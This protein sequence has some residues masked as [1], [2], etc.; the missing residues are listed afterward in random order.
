M[1]ERISELE[2]L[3]WE[4]IPCAPYWDGMPGKHEL[5]TTEKVF[6]KEKFAELIVRECVTICEQQRTKILQNPN[7]PSWTEHLAEVQTNIKQH[8]KVEE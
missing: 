7:D 1:N 8:F 6:N 4:D 5:Y 3:C 2:A